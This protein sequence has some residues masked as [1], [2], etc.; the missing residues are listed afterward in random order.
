M[1]VEIIHQVHW[2]NEH[3]DVGAVIDV[4]ETDAQWLISRKK[5]IPYVEKA[6]IEN[7]AVA[8]PE[9]AQPKLSKRT[10][11]KSESSAS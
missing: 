1:K 7:R 6:E 2:D 3:R 10:W 5:A 8:L 4:K 11:K 9:S